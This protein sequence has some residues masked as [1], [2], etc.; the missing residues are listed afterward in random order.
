MQLAPGGDLMDKI[1]AMR[2]GQRSIPEALAKNIFGQICL[3]VGMSFPLCDYYDI[4][5]GIR[6][7]PPSLGFALRH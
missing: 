5:S 6:S 2:K 1:L 4:H 7:L 3:A